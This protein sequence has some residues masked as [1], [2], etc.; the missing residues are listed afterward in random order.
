M[1][2]RR[3]A[4]SQRARLRCAMVLSAVVLAAIVSMV[5]RARDTIHTLPENLDYMPYRFAHASPSD[6]ARL[7]VM[8]ADLDGD[9]IDEGIALS[10]NRRHEERF[11]GVFFIEESQR[12]SITQMNK[13]PACE[14]LGVMDLTGDGQ[15]ELVWSEQRPDNIVEFAVT[16][17]DTIKIDSGGHQIGSVLW[18][19]TGSTMDDGIW[20]GA[21]YLISAF[22]RDENGTR[23]TLLL[24]VNTGIRLTPRGLW[25]L[26]WESGRFVGKRETA[27]TPR[28]GLIVDVDGDGED[29]IVIAL[30]SPGNGAVS[31]PFDDGHSYVAVFE[32][33]LSLTWW[34]E[35]GGYTS[36]VSYAVRDL[37][38]DGTME[39]VT[40]VG[41]H[42]RGL[43]GDLV[44]R[45]WDGATGE[46]LTS[47][48]FD[49]P[50]NDLTTFPSVDGPR[51]CVGL[52][53]GR[54]LRFEY[55]GS[56]LVQD[57]EFR[58]AD[59]VRLVR[60]M[61]FGVTRQAPTLVVMTVNGTVVLVNEELVP[62]AA[63]RTT[64]AISVKS[65]VA[66]A[67]FSVEGEITPGM[68]FQTSDHQYYIYAKRVS[69]PPW[70]RRAIDW[71]R[72]I[73]SFLIVA[74]VTLLVAAVALPRYRRQAVGSLRR[75]LLP[76]RRREAELDEFLEQ[77]KT[78][79]HGMLSATKT[80]RRLAGQFTML[81]QHE[82]D[83]PSAFAERY[84]EAIDNAR[85]VGLPTVRGIVE[86]ARR[87][88]LAPLETPALARSLSDVERVVDE[89][90]ASPPAATAASAMRSRIE[91]DLAL[92]ERGI[93]V[94]RRDAERE[95]S[96]VLSHELARVLSARAVELRQP[97]VT[98][99]AAAVGK[100]EG[101]RVVGTAAELTFVFDNLI[102]NA[103]RAVRE[104]SNATIRLAVD[105]DGNAVAVDVED[106]G[107]G[108]APAEHD[109]I[110]LRGVSEREGG[111]HGL[112]RSREI[113]ERR[114]GSIELVRSAPGEGAVFKVK[115]KVVSDDV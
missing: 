96:C 69:L 78:G 110:F 57:A 37:D 84:R 113:L 94:A 27:A 95:R 53:D 107:T 9:G 46:P 43:E 32:K 93:G 25:L 33:D 13:S 16:E 108:I 42:H 88:G 70:L 40:G 44:V 62:L 4:T 20:G 83:A 28:D 77:L 34:Q 76:R 98:V 85:D 2:E 68:I 12:Y 63:W 103:L 7:Q 86:S 19:A 11:I 112:P 5:V 8:A 1:P 106:T 61:D 90:P 92:L 6:E 66:P 105:I 31:E 55:T 24:G 72:S 15:H 10:K 3:Y 47:I 48:P 102:G 114:G 89:A 52:A 18:D 49:V 67:R 109:R 91:R 50:I 101:I 82:G 60:T 29:E 38:G 87:L 56:E 81:S 111:G 23:E 73:A 41:G 35:L 75:R 26:D 65:Q 74:I 30:E 59:G 17:F 71:L 79:G 97:G 100:L 99:D 39:I 14:L 36:L 64:E 104:V 51:L 22:D 80:L 45:V 54:V 115:L 21:A 58:C